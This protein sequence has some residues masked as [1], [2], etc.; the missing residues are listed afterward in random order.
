MSGDHGSEEATPVDIGLSSSKEA[1]SVFDIRPYSSDEAPKIYEML[2]VPNWAPWL[3]ATSET[4]ARRAEVFPEGQIAVWDGNRPVASISLNRFN[5]D[6]NPENLPTWD[7]L[8]GDPSTYEETFVPDGNAVAMMSINV[9]P[10]Y[11]RKGL[12]EDIIM[13]VR[14]LR[15]SSPGLEHIMGSF[16]PSQFGEYSHKNPR[17]NFTHYTHLRRPD[18]WPKD[19]WLRALERNGMIRLRDDEFAMM[20]PN[21]PLEELEQYKRS[22][23]PERWKEVRSGIWRCG[24]TGV[25]VVQEKV[26]VYMEGNVWGILEDDVQNGNNGQT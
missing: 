11:Q 7:Q 22:Y 8:A 13:A 18:R 20:V 3:R 14:E 26:A 23:Y 4:L 9:H 10:D 15:E 17:A 24:Q 6:G 2:E 19:A 21:V 12:T 16:R 25:W 1:P 5:Y